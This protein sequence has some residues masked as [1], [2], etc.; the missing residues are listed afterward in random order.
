MSLMIEASHPK[1][2]FDFSAA[3]VG[4]SV[5]FVAGYLA[6]KMLCSRKKDDNFR[7]V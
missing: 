5:G 3:A 4:T 7:R 1:T 2:S 6:M